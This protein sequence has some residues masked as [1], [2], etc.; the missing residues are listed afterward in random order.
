[1]SPTPSPEDGNRIILRDV[2]FFSVLYNTGRLTKSRNPI[3]PSGWVRFKTGSN[4][5]FCEYDNEHSDFIKGGEFH[6]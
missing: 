5:G 6:D 1:V 4:C 2:G 3:I